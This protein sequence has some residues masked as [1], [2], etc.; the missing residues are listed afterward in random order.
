MIAYSEIDIAGT[1]YS[2]KYSSAKKGVQSIKQSVLS[3]F[4]VLYL[5]CNAFLIVQRFDN[6][7]K[8]T[9]LVSAYRGIVYIHNLS[10]AIASFKEGEIYLG[11][12]MRSELRYTA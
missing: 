5:Y 2:T 4:L 12:R 8:E 9:S 1:G 3:D 6:L 11:M 10:W 7:S